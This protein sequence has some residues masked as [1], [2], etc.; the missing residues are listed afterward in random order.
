M[1][2]KFIQCQYSSSHV[3]FRKY[4]CVYRVLSDDAMG[5]VRLMVM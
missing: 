2:S 1:R 5:E 3:N 4:F